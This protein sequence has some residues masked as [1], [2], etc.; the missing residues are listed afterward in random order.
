VAAPSALRGSEDG[1]FESVGGD[2]DIVGHR[3]GN[4]SAGPAA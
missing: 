3:A 2:P 4:G 1:Q